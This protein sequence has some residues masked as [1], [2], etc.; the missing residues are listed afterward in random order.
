MSR[1]VIQRLQV[2]HPNC[3]VFREIRHFFRHFQSE[4]EIFQKQ[5]N[6]I[7]LSSIIFHEKECILHDSFS[8]LMNT[9]VLIERKEK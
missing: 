1:G 7:Y 8:Y 2:K 3:E 6:A 4:N 9:C 5:I